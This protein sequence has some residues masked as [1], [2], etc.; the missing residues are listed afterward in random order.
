MA[1]LN[2]SDVAT[3]TLAPGQTLAVTMGAVGT[4]A[5]RRNAASA[6]AGY[7]SIIR[8]AASEKAT[9]GP[10]LSTENFVV[11]C[12]TGSL[13]YV[14]ADADAQ[15]RTSSV[16][17]TKTQD[18]SATEADSVLLVDATGGNVTIT[19]PPAAALGAG[20]SQELRIKRV[21]SSGN[22]VTVQVAGADALD[23]GT[24]TTVAMASSKDFQ[25]DGVAAWYVF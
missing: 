10:F 6:G 3:L 15:V 5:V 18:Y 7:K 19:L 23:G 11:W 14:V 1:T 17:A 24:S 4:G 12:Y 16:I 22:T 2:Q 9:Y 13:S 21:D 20:F 25:S 8:L